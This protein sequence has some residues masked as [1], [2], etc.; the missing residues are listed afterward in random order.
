[1]K[2]DAEKT[3]LAGIDCT[4]EYPA[5]RYFSTGDDVVVESGAGRYREA[6]A[7][8]LSRFGYR[9]P[10]AHVGR[11]HLAVIRYPDDRRRFMCVMDGTCYDL[12]TGITSGFAYPVSGRMREIRQVFWPR[13]QDCTLVFMT[14]GHDEPAAVA[15]IDI[16][17]LDSL[18][19]LNLPAPPTGIA[20]RELGIQYEDPCGT[21]ASEGALSDRKSVV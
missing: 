18:P 21:G 2:P 20:R 10:I 1:M 11:P 13:W 9:F 15:S 3:K 7:K 8:P 12:S 5:D 14:W 6:T 19:S 16:Y 4:Q 17:E